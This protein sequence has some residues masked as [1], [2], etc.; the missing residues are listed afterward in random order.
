MDSWV[1]LAASDLEADPMAGLEANP[2]VD[3]EAGLE[4]DAE[5]GLEVVPRV[6]RVQVQALVVAFIAMA[7]ELAQLAIWVAVSEPGA[8]AATMAVVSKAITAKVVTAVVVAIVSAIAGQEVPTGQMALKQ[9]SQVGEASVARAAAIATVMAASIA[10]AVFARKVQVTITEVVS[11][12]GL[13]LAAA[14]VSFG[15]QLEP[16]FAS[17]LP[18]DPQLASTCAY[19]RLLL[20]L[21]YASD[22]TQAHL[23]RCSNELCG[24]DGRIE[25][26]RSLPGSPSARGSGTHSTPLYRGHT[27]M[28][29]GSS[30]L[31]L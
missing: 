16:G 23:Q 14:S 5:I 25:V 9:V 4:V 12:A 7:D 11:I 31:S 29:N 27:C 24:K 28:A 6:S 21:L 13:A 3:P 22:H 20:A 10:A 18:F 15:L 2:V 8:E 19:D 26:P 30:K 1:I 17:L